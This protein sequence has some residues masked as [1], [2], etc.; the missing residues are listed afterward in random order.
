MGKLSGSRSKRLG[1]P[2]P[3]IAFLVD[4]LEDPYQSTLLAGAAA[5]ASRRGVTLLVLPGG[6]LGGKTKNGLGRNYLF[7]L[8]RRPHFDGA[9]VLSGTLG[10]QHGVAAVSDLVA[11]FD[12]V[13]VV[14][15]AVPL[16]GHSAVVVDNKSGMRRAIEHLV[17]D[18]GYRRIAF[19]RGPEVNAEAEA[20]FQAYVEVL[21]EH[22]IA[23]D[24]DLVL[25]GDFQREGGSQA[26]RTLFDERHV[27]AASLHAIAGATDLMVMGAIE[28][29]ERRGLR[30][31][32]DLAAIG[33][34]DLEESRYL[35]PPL[36]SVRQPLAEQGAEALRLLLGRIAGLER[37]PL[38]ALET[39]FVRRRSCG[40]L[41][42]ESVVGL[43]RDSTGSRLSFGAEL[44]RGRDITLAEMTRAARGSFVG[45]ER[46]WEE[47]LLNALV[48]EFASEA[49]AAGGPFLTAL[50]RLLVQVLEA[51]GDVAIGHD[52]VS[53]V[54]R[55]LWLA[56]FDDAHTGRRIEDV[57]HDARILISTLVE[58]SQAR[59]RL[60]AQAWAR[61]LGDV[62]AQL[63]GVSGQADLGQRIAAQM[64]RLGLDLCLVLEA[65]ADLGEQVTLRFAWSSDPRLS[66]GNLDEVYPARDVFP[67]TFDGSLSGTFVVLPLS[68]P[69]ERYG[70]AIVSHGDVDGYAFE[71]LREL[72][73]AGTLAVRRMQPAPSRPG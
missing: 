52:L 45:A 25:S 12:G 37:D 41:P 44:I 7:D 73:S 18:H 39:R 19:I 38:R 32:N 29:L 48:E 8:V 27:P 11:S 42:R 72:L 68:R 70:F 21:G 51:G 28:E 57:L 36:T 6:I 66:L 20:R 69:G 58:R 5:E 67:S 9:I 4:W 59:A 1:G 34:D 55:Q 43:A 17:V 62:S 30:V 53:A 10:N 47:R 31:P 63:A 23:L 60:K 22:G 56:A 2:P 16:L 33:F 46:G 3:R 14:S 50:D 24:G 49:R 71:M 65:E 64:P 40:C 13:P 35:S 15:I 61:L 54:R 26:M